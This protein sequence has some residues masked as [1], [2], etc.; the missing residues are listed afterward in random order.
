M[1]NE[2]R[3]QRIA[4][5]DM[6]NRFE[7]EARAFN[8]RPDE[9]REDMVAKAYVLNSSA[10]LHPL[11]CRACGGRGTKQRRGRARGTVPCRVC[12]GTGLVQRRLDDD[13][14]LGM[15]P[16]K[17]YWRGRRWWRHWRR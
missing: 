10:C 11:T 12:Q 15:R 7:D 3:K 4:Y 2:R 14:L 1:K 9:E 13:R 8:A 16:S 5:R 6:A 17:V